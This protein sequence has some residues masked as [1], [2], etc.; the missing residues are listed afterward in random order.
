MKKRRIATILLFFLIHTG[1]SAEYSWNKIDN[2]KLNLPIDWEQET[3]IDTYENEIL[4]FRHKKYRDY[5]IVLTY[6]LLIN[7]DSSR[8][9]AFFDANVLKRRKFE[10][11]GQANRHV[12]LLP[13]YEIDYRYY[14]K[15]YNS[16]EKDYFLMKKIYVVI[17]RKYYA[18]RFSCPELYY[19]E[20]INFITVILDNFEIELVTDING[21][22]LPERQ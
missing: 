16:F 1:F 12:N 18:L 17:G 8:N 15:V 22:R 21:N 6:K 7:L 10:I 20:Y 5:T 13:A 14:G 11:V 19:N 4:K 9:Y 2:I 3:D